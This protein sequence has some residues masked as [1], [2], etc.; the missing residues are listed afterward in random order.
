MMGSGA[1]VVGV[2]MH[3]T[4]GVSRNNFFFFCFPANH[5]DLPSVF[6]F[7]MRIFTHVWTHLQKIEKNSQTRIYNMTWPRIERG[8][9]TDIEVFNYPFLVGVQH[10]FYKVA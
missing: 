2:R 8:L 4:D 3:V 1:A 10:W 7:E 9:P 6:A 5:S